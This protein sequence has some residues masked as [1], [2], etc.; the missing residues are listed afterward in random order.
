MFPIGFLHKLIPPA[1]DESRGE[2][3]REFP[4]LDQM[5]RLP[6]EL[7][8]EIGEWVLNSGD[9][10]ANWKHRLIVLLYAESYSEDTAEQNEM[11]A[12]CLG[13]RSPF[14]SRKIVGRCFEEGLF[15]EKPKDKNFPFWAAFY[16]ALE[17]YG[18]GAPIP[19]ISKGFPLSEELNEFRPFP[20]KTIMLYRKGYGGL[21]RRE[22]DKQSR[23]IKLVLKGIAEDP[24]SEEEN[25]KF[26]RTVA[27]LYPDLNSWTPMHWAAY[28]GDETSALR[29]ANHDLSILRRKDGIDQISLHYVA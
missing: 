22:L 23:I 20:L 27:R 8:H 13:P 7:W 2:R 3:H 14:F 5:K 17:L 24:A 11:R 28:I 6:S 19:G 18:N 25:R 15:P 26:E 12:L 9:P 29:F 1:Q 10:E 4:D 16:H 21:A